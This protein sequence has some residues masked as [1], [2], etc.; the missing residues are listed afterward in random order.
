MRNLVKEYIES[1]KSFEDLKTEYGINVNEFDNLICLNYNQIESPKTPNIVRQCR[2]I[3]L[4]KNTLEIVHYPFF[5]FFNLD[6]MPEERHKFNWNNAFGLQKIDGSLFGVF[7]H[8]GVWHITTRSQ[9]GGFNKVTMCML[10]FGDIFDMAIK[11][12]REDFFAKLNPEL[13]YT[14]ELVSPYNKVVTPYSEPALYIIGVRDKSNEFKEI[15]IS[16]IYD[17]LPEY[18]KHP[19][20]FSI[21]DT[22]GNFIGFE[23]MK[24]LANGLENPT[25]EGFVVVDYSSYNDEFG[26]Y[27]RIKVKNVSYVALHH[28]RGSMENGAMN[29][30]GI[31]E[32]IWKNE[33]DEVLA[34][35]PE[36]KIFFDE[37]KERLDNFMKYEKDAEEKVAKYW[38]IP[39]EKRSEPSIKKDFALTID[40][41]WSLFF[42]GMFKE[43]KTF[44]EWI[45]LQTHKYKNYYKKLWEENVS[46]F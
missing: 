43:G 7:C 22:N 2:G 34:N 27:P 15:N 3:V 39:M 11:E 37:V 20:L 9:I 24:A 26:Y 12:S 45:E 18:I 35:F 14:F 40:K 33:Q 10:A 23:E 36:F 41:R 5:R 32:I 46:K 13:D 30:G 1:G 19:E 8:N 21:K 17:K 38:K 6:E 28:L 44:R 42:F 25:D 4:D 29:Y 16:E 31:L